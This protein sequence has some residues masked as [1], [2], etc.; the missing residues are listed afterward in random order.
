MTPKVGNFEASKKGNH[1]NGLSKAHLI[2]N[3]PSTLL[4]MELPQPFDPCLLISWGGK[5]SKEGDRDKMKEGN[6]NKTSTQKQQNSD[7]KE[8]ALN[9]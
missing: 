7:T 5:S 9:K 4:A 2:T 3:N 6:T 8:E 1:L